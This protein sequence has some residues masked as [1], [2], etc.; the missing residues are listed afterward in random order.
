MRRRDDLI[1]PMSEYERRLSDLRQRMAERGIEVMIST[2][3]ENICYISG[4]ESPG[5]YYFFALI[6]P[7][8]GEVIAVPR[9]LEDSGIEE[10]TYIE[11][12]RPYNDSE[13]PIDKL[14]DTLKEFSF[15]DK[16]IGIERGSWFFTALQQ[17][18]L[19]A[20]CP[21]TTFIDCTGIIEQGRLIKSS[22]EIDLMRKAA[23]ATIAGMQAGIDAVQVGAT[24]DDVAADIHYAMIK[25]GSQWPSIAPFVAA[26][27]RG[28]IG[29]ATWMGRTIEQNEF[30]MI[31]VG[32]CVRRYHTAMMR[33]VYVGKPSEDVLA[34]VQVV[35]D[36][37]D[38]MLSTIKPG[39]SAHDADAVGR[40]IISESR[41]GGEQASRS[42]YSIGIG[43]P[44]DWGEGHIL[45]M[46]PD[47]TRLLQEN[48]TFHVLPWVQ[49]PGEGG[50][51]FSNTVRVTTDGCEL[52]TDFPR[53]LFAK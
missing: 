34:A 3:P 31:E 7:I 45:S 42:A 53:E 44:P 39:I 18:H 26:G 22:H 49:V 40:K 11:I 21:D 52:L 5:H 27:Y 16:R 1:F 51:S 43:L 15:L 19:M 12:R 23:K 32:G 4:F 33:T 20:K 37:I 13:H 28:A 9:K 48:M 36:A 14:Y 30:V 38:A 8:E 25:A 41:F 17:E 6:V 50:I 46:Q 29:H 2:T 10:Y 24:E 35:Q 47:E